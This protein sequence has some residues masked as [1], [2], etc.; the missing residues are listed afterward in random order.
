MKYLITFL[1]FVLQLTARAGDM[2]ASNLGLTLTIYDTPCANALVLDWI[3]PKEHWRYKMGVAWDA[4]DALF[5]CW[6]WT[7]EKKQGIFLVF[8]DGT[9]HALDVQQ[10]KPI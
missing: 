1:L 9:S 3:A 2:E 7:N 6:A 8:P 10:F 4:E 5:L